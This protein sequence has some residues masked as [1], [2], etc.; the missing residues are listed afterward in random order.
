[1]QIS[2]N[3]IYTVFKLSL[4]S[5]DCTHRIFSPLISPLLIA[6]HAAT[7]DTRLFPGISPSIIYSSSLHSGV[8]V[9]PYHLW[10]ILCSWSSRLC[11]A[12]GERGPA[13]EIGWHRWERLCR[14]AG[15]MSPPPGEGGGWRKWPTLACFPSNDFPPSLHSL[16]RPFLMC[17]TSNDPDHDS[18]SEINYQSRACFCIF[19]FWMGG[20]QSV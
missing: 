4:V 18:I 15:K 10:S 16:L 8:P 14:C 6:F 17:V 9:A 20:C 11:N 13:A 7:L 2:Y 19:F 1:M 12:L 5:H 3:F